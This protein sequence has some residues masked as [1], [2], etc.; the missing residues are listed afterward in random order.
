MHTF[1]WSVSGG[2]DL[3]NNNYP[4][5]LVGAYESANAIY[6]KSAPVVHLDSMLEFRVPGKNVDLE[7][8]N[9]RLNDGT[10]VTCVSIDVSMEYDGVGVPD[11]ISK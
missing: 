4:D 10:K 2:M 1:G 11:S 5:V 9:C 6:F 3:D 8:R 7:Q